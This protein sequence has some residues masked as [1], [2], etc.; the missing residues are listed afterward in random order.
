MKTLVLGVGNYLLRDEGVGIHAVQALEKEKLPPGVDVLDGGTGGLHL[1]GLLQEYNRILMIDATLDGH[2]PGTI[3][4]IRPR[5]AS[6][7]PPRMSAHEI[8]LHDLFKALHLCGP[9]P[10]IDLLVVSVSSV[11]EL[12]IRLSP[13]VAAALPELLRRAKEWYSHE[14]RHTDKPPQP[15]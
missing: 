6:D 10:Q 3:R 13:P 5:Y 15:E 2:P 8:G 12:G 11:G 7:F 1:L 14:S 4:H 9:V